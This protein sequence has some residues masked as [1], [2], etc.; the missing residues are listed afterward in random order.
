MVLTYLYG[1]F[2]FQFALPGTWAGP[3]R[4]IFTSAP[5]LRATASVLCISVSLPHF[6]PKSDDQ[7]NS[8]MKEPSALHNGDLS[9]LA[10]TRTFFISPA[11]QRVVSARVLDFL[12]IISCPHWFSFLPPA[13]LFLVPTARRH[14]NFLIWSCRLGEGNTTTFRGLAEEQLEV[15]M[16][17]LQAC[18]QEP[19]SKHLHLL[20]ILLLLGDF[21][22]SP[23]TPHLSWSL[24]SNALPDTV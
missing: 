8:W 18:L 5:L 21:I 22:S 12:L 15:H 1:I 20:L 7:V 13:H 11:Q 17:C 2:I 4:R 16:G 6:A 3:S 24:C 23:A 14:L 19:W 10:G 9:L